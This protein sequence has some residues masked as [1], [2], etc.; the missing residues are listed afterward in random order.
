[1]LTATLENK[2]PL[3]EKEKKSGNRGTHSQQKLS[4]L[5]FFQHCHE[6]NQK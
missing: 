6:T 5:N 4:I 1:M 2:G 3:Q